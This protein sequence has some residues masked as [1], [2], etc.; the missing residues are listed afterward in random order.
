MSSRR[1]IRR[2]AFI[3][4]LFFPLFWLI[5]IGRVPLFDLDETTYA[6]CSREMWVTRNYFY[7]QMAFLPFWEKPPGFFW[8]Q[9]L[10]FDLWGVG[11]F[12]ARFPN[13]VVGGLT[14][15]MLFRLGARWHGEVFGLTWLF[16]YA[17]SLL[18]SFYARS[19]IIDP[20]FNLL[21]LLATVV[22]VQGLVSSPLRAGITFGVLTGLAT[23][24]K[25]PVGLGLPALA[26]ASVG[27][28]RRKIRAGF[29]VALGAIVPYLLLVGG[30]LVAMTLSGKA[31]VLRDFWDYQL[32]LFLRPFGGHKGP[33]YYHLVVLLVGMFPASVWA[34]RGW[35]LRHFPLPAQGLLFLTGWTILL[36]SLVQTKIIHYSSLAYYGIAYLGARVGQEEQGWLRRWGW[37]SVAAGGILLGFCTVLLGWLMTQRHLWEGLIRDPFAQAAL[38]NTPLNWQGSEGWMGILLIAGISLISLLSIKPHQR[39]FGLGIVL[40]IWEILALSSF[41]PR[42]EAYTQ[43]P[44]RAFTEAKAREGALVWPLGFRTAITFFYGNM[45]PHTSPH[46]TKDVEAFQTLLLK[47]EADLPF[48]YYFVSRVDRYKPFLEAYPL[49]VISQEGGYVFL[50]LDRQRFYSGRGCRVGSASR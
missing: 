20:T 34:L 41:A 31:G 49:H 29:R 19:A 46:L 15:A 2:I 44:L 42:I 18:P 13:I 6:E 32:G 39:L 23:L 22:G 9:S 24:V 10:S 45:Y 21:M 7:A 11:S 1:H 5:G 14:L 30:W 47:G 40:I 36:F 8:L 27:V 4:V 26:V 16:L 43:G 50:E 25:G 3:L 17:I 28:W 35:H 33:W 48:A 38:Q 12:G 37:P